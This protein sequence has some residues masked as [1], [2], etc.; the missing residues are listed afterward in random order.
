M[1]RANMPLESFVL[2]FFSC[3][4]FTVIASFL[5]SICSNYSP[6]LLSWRAYY[7]VKNKRLQKLLISE[8]RNRSQ[9][10]KAEPEDRNK[11]AFVGCVIWV[12]NLIWTVITWSTLIYLFVMGLFLSDVEAEVLVEQVQ[13]FFLCFF[14]MKYLYFIAIMFACYQLDYSIGK[15]IHSKKS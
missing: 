7:V 8:R 5:A 14:N 13:P 6:C 11:M 1:R 15:Y 3:I 10:S 12:V 4:I 9:D 2:V